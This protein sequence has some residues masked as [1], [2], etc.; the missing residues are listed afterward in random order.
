MT[1]RPLRP[2]ET[3]A[4]HALWQRS[5]PLDP[6]SASVFREKLETAPGLAVAAGEV[7]APAAVGVGV[8]WPT[9][10][11]VRGSVRLLAVDPSARRRGLGRRLL[12]A[13]EEALRQRGA[14]VARLAE[15]APNYLTPGVDVRN[16]GA[17]ALAEACGYAPIGEAVNLGVD[18]TARAWDTAADEARLTA[19]GV[20]VR[21]ATTAD[22]PALAELLA[23]RWPPWEAE[24]DRALAH[25]TPTLHLALRD[26]AVVGFAA[27]DANNV[28]TG[29]FGPMGTDP[30]ARGL[31]IGRVLLWRCLADMRRAGRDRATIAW[32]AALPFY[33]DAC[34]AT[35][36][37][38]FRRFEKPL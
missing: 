38:R 18:L 34:G 6:V 25:P 31:G 9:A 28:G 16:A 13:L 7:G 2:S 23:A 1:L 11:A 8:L 10:E 29:W 26:G 37:R 17:L 27:H 20:G 19:V 24:T 36:E 33:E 12:S 4:A 32:A 14:T 15:A 3:D 21:R 30:S 22:R 5:A 35:V